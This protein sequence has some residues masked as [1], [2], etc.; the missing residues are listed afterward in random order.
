MSD[1]DFEKAM[2]G[3]EPPTDVGLAQMRFID[4]EA[5][6]LHATSYP[7]E[8]AWCGLDLQPVSML[9]RPLPYWG[10]ADWNPEA[11]RIH[12]ISREKLVREGHDP[13][14]C[15]E[16]MAKALQGCFSFSDAPEFDARWLNRLFGDTGVFPGFGLRHLSLAHMLCARRSDP[17]IGS[18]QEMDESL[19]AVNMRY[20]HTHRAGDDCLRMAAQCRALAD[21]AWRAKAGKAA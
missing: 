6:G 21:S 5:S 2:A 12:G 16:A 19:Q 17:P 18:W 20:L 9:I 11:E 1:A 7:I 10:E 14:E 4:V 3:F 15:A 8:I 13:R